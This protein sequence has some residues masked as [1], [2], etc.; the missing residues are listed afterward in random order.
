MMDEPELKEL[1]K[2]MRDEY[3]EVTLEILEKCSLKED[4]INEFIE[5]NRLYAQIKLVQHIL[6]SNS[7]ASL[8]EQ[9]KHN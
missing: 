9:A 7:K 5:Q 4:Y 2:T 6:E 8:V 3:D 1:L